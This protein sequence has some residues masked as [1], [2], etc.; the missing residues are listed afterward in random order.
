MQHQLSPARKQLIAER[1]WAMRHAL[2]PSESTLWAAISCKQ[3]G[4]VFKRQQPIGKYIADFV[5]PSVKVIVEVDG[6]YH[7]RRTTADER[8]DRYLTRA[9]YCVVHITAEIVVRQL[10]LALERIRAALGQLP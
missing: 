7:A 1:A 10:P 6:G 9:G 4:V 3:L 2:T 8:R 5:A